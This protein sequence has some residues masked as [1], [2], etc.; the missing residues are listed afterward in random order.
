MVLLAFVLLAQFSR[1]V[2]YF[3][4]ILLESYQETNIEVSSTVYGRFLGLLRLLRQQ[5][6]KSW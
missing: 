4:A 1:L 3:V 2:S 6:Y 5:I